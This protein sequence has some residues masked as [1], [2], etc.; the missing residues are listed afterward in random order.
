M[1]NTFRDSR[2]LFFMSFIILSSCKS[3][4]LVEKSGQWD[5][6]K[7]G[8]YLVENN[9]WNVQATKR[10][11]TETIFYDTINSSMG[12]KWD[13]SNEKTDSLLVKSFPEII[14]GKKPYINYQSTTSRLPIELTSSQFHLEY[15]YF[16]N[17]N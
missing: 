16:V 17:A 9:T 8:E 10:K 11:W 14:F 13:F 3:H 5:Q 7:H 2:Y 6:I 15:E 4:N 12:W 1:N